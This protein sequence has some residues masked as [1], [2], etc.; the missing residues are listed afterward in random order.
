MSRSKRNRVQGQGAAEEEN[1]DVP[2]RPIATPIYVRLP[3]TLLVPC[4][5]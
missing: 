1:V 3:P 2:V 5:Q 4:K